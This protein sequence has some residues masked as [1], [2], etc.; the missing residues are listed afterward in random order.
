MR[1]AWAPPSMEGS[2]RL[3]PSFICDDCSCF[4]EGALEEEGACLAGTSYTWRIADLSDSTWRWHT[5]ACLC[6][7]VSSS[8]VRGSRAHCFSG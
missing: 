5:T 7:R 8:E 4:E 1:E 6:A 2:W 3:R